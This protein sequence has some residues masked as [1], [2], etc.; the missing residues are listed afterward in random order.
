MPAIELDMLIAFVNRRDRLHPVA[1]RLFE[2]I[3]GGSLE[4][5]AVPASALMEYE[6]VLRSRGYDEARIREDIQAFKRID[7]VREIPLNSDILLAASSL[8]EQHGLS[9]FDSLHAASAL[10]HDG[11][12][13]SVDEC[14]RRVPGLKAIDPR[15]LV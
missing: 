2:M 3:A 9:Y 14:Y 12:I 15:E 5:V 4:N 11:I 8:R 10:L 1:A 13:I 7:N 6:L